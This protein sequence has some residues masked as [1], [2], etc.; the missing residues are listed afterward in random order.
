MKRGI[1]LVA[2]LALLLSLTAVSAQ[3]G[4]LRVAV[5]MP[6]SISDLAWSQAIYSALVEIQAEMGGESALEIGYTENMFDVAAAGQ[7]LRD[8][9]DDGYDIVIAHGT[10]YG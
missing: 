6:S 2:V 9:A 3:D 1:L 7:A 8:Y 5:V 4:P 10:Q